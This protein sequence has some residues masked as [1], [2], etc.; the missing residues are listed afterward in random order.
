MIIR[1]LII[2]REAELHSICVISMKNLQ[3]L[4]SKKRGKKLYVFAWTFLLISFWTD[5]RDWN[6]NSI[7]VKRKEK[8]YYIF[9]EFIARKSISEPEN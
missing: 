1:Q 3:Y 7:N 6:T 5:A 9:P 2:S 4:S 8:S